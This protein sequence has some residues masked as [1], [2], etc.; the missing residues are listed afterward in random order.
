MNPLLKGSAMCYKPMFI[1]T[2]SFDPD[3]DFHTFFHRLS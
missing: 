1:K 3:T 2:V